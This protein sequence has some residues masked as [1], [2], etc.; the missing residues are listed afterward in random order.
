MLRVIDA[1]A[2]LIEPS[3]PLLG[4]GSMVLTD[5]ISAPYPG[6]SVIPYQ[7]HVTYD[8]RLLPGETRNLVLDALKERLSFYDIKSSIEIKPNTEVTYAGER[9]AGD[10]FFPAWV[11]PEEHTLVQM[12]LNGLKSANINPAIQAYRFC[13]NAVYSA[14][15][16]GIP[17]IGFGIGREEDA[18][19]IDESISVADLETAM[20]GYQGIIRAVCSDK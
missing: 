6:R 2:S 8:R 13:T 18:H 1:I 16:A 20:R 7:C 5:I 11:F 17:T 15:T 12:A 9:L 19:I 10:K 4:A 14:G 3:H